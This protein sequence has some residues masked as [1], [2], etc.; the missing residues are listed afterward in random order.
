MKHLPN[1]L[2]ICRFILIPF[3]IFGLLTGHF[4][5]A[6]ILFSISAITDIADGYIARKFNYITNFGKLADPLAD[7]LT[8]LSILVTLSIYKIIPITI[9]IIFFIKDLIL[10]LASFILYKKNIIMYSKWYGKA[11]TCL[12]YISIVL[13]LP[14]P[15]I[16]SITINNPEKYSLF[17]S[18]YQNFTSILYIFTC[19]FA[20]FAFFMYAINTI[21]YL[22]K[23]YSNYR[24][25]QFN[26]K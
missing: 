8:Q 23:N 5:L 20:V 2:T 4:F 21:M 11:A 15:Y 14:K 16:S 3:I 26:I 6:F 9:F 13:S 7:K 1:I 25:T 19:G 18:N 12:L 17:F 24:K 22:F 10:I